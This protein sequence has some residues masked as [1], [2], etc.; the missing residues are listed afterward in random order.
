[1]FEF[2]YFSCTFVTEPSTAIEIL[3]ELR[4]SLLEDN[5][6][7]SATLLKWLSHSSSKLF[8]P[9]IWKVSVTFSPVFLNKQC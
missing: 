1:M 2:M 5:F 3:E 9:V 6:S 4:L 7:I 8:L